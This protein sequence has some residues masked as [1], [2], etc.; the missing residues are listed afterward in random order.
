MN[1]K[2]DPELFINKAKISY[3]YIDYKENEWTIEEK[4]TNKSLQKIYDDFSIKKIRIYPDGID[5]YYE[6]DVK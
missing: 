5:K 4:L 3:Q 6:L 1:E 2:I